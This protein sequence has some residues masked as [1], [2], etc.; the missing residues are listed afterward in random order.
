MAFVRM[1]EM[2]VDKVV[3]VIAMGHRFMAAA[4][5]M[6]MARLVARA[7]V[8]GR[9][10]VGVL[11][12]NLQ[13]AFIDVVAVHGVQAAVVQVVHVAAVADGR[14]AAALAVDVRVLRMDFVLRHSQPSVISELRRKG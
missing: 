2:A 14:V 4:G 13:H 3:D 5:T 6:H 1:V 12:G 8:G 9:A 10:G 7:G 11:R